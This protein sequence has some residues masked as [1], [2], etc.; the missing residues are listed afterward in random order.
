MSLDL[1]HVQVKNS[2]TFGGVGLPTSSNF[3]RRG[4]GAYKTTC[5]PASFPAD[6]R[7]HRLVRPTFSYE[8]FTPG[9][10]PPT[11]GSARSRSA[12]TAA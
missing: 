2:N 12:A 1:E 6:P 3:V 4:I 10:T 5:K 7:V 11:P 8:R 9:V